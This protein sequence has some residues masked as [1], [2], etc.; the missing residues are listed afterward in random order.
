MIGCILFV[1]NTC[2]PNLIFS[3]TTPTGGDMGAHLVGPSYIIHHLLTHG[4]I[5]GWDPGWYA[6]F[7]LFEFYMV[8]PSLMVVFLDLGV[9]NPI[10]LVPALAFVVSFTFSGF[11]VPALRRWRK[12]LFGVGIFWLLCTIPVPYNIAFKLVTISGLLLLPFAA[13]AFGK[14]TDLPFPGPP[15]LALGSLFVIY[16]REPNLNG[17]TGNIIGGNM[18]STM[19]GEFCFMLSLAFCL[20]YLGFLINGMRTG[21]HRGAAAVMLALTGL[22]HL[23]PVFFALAAT[24]VALVV[25]PGK[26]RLKWAAYVLPVGGLLAAFW[27]VP[28]EL[29]GKFVND[30]GWE[31]LPSPGSMTTGAHPH[32]QTIWDYITPHALWWPL[33]LALCGLIVS[34]VYR[35]RAGIFLTITMVGSACALRWVPQAQLWNARLLPFYY[36]SMFL[37]AA[38]GVSEVVR[39]IG[40]LVAKDPDKPGPWVH[41]HRRWLR[42]VAFT[43]V[44]LGMPLGNLPGTS[45]PATGGVNW[46]GLHRAYR[47]DVPGWAAWNYSGLEAK[48]V[49]VGTGGS[50]PTG[51]GGWPE[52]HAMIQ[53]M[54][55]LGTEPD[56]G[57]GRAMWEYDGDRLNTYGTPMAPMLLPYYTDNCIDS[58]EGLYFESSATTPYHFLTQCELSE[59]G[60]CAQRD[61]DYGSFN[62]QL[63]IEQEELMGVKYYMAFSPTA[64][65]AANADSALTQVA[66][67]GPWHVYQLPAAASAVV[68]GLTNQPVVMKNIANGQGSW[69]DPSAAWYL[70]PSDYD[71]M[72]AESGPKD[73]TR[74]TIPADP[75]AAPKEAQFNSMAQ[76]TKASVDGV[77]PPPA[78]GTSRTVA[79]PPPDAARAARSSRRRCPTSSPPTTASPSTSTR[80]ARRSW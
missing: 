73:W 41:P 65:D 50:V 59:H 62:L 14:L 58:M 16:N 39:S 44:F 53:T 15:I 63:G 42:C 20:L 80:S 22:C 24:V 1:F 3:N 33:A 48:P 8:V 18:A 46:L 68:T 38:V 12:V 17:G 54:A 10:L 34:I 60:S 36:L 74:I 67:T 26:N 23:I 76:P 78:P 11:F 47:N 4:E 75:I 13:W 64:V 56:H 55:K 43:L 7:P 27:I 40:S 29:R 69:L 21:R 31:K 66:V 35:Y 45:F 19:A 72:M 51:Q 30:M 61:L 49:Q 79:W 32:A 25:W 77:A 28:F 57:C 37:L 70:N 2:H 5:A 9:R 52:L 6:G 71:V